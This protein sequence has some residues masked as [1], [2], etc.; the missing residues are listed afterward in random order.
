MKNI[1]NNIIKNIVININ[2]LFEIK[3]E[4]KLARFEKLQ[5]YLI[6]EYTR[7]VIN[8]FKH[9][10]I[11]FKS[12]LEKFKYEYLEGDLRKFQLYLN[13]NFSRYIYCDL[14][15]NDNPLNINDTI[16]S[17]L[18]IEKDE[19]KTKRNKL[20]NSIKTY[21]KHKTFFENL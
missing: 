18:L 17:E 7:I 1:K 8:H 5:N 11:W 9:I 21:K 16:L 10:D 13:T 14:C 15:H 2:N 12:Y 4:Y 6:N 3:N 20:N 19:W